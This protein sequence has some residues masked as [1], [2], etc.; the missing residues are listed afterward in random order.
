[1]TLD[2][3]ERTDLARHFGASLGREKAEELI[4]DTARGLGIEGGSYDKADTLR[5]LE[6]LATAQGLVGI[7]ARFAKVRIILQ[8]K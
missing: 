7:V 3:V 1:M 8:F 5:I 2:K 6:R 4:A